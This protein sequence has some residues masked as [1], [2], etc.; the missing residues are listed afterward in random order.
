MIEKDP[1]RNKRWICL[2]SLILGRDVLSST[3][4]QPCT[5]L[6]GVLFLP[7]LPK[8]HTNQDPVKS[9]LHSYT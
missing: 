2:V 9:Q 7:F 4:S 6:K 1:V 3:V 5:D 8:T